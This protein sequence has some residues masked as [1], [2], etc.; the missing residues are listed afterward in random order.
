MNQKDI[1]EAIQRTYTNAQRLLKDSE[2]LEKKGSFASAVSLAILGYEEAMK[3]YQLTKYHPIFDGFFAKADLILLQKQL[4]SHFWKQTF[5]LELRISLEAIIDALS[6]K[7]RKEI[8]MPSRKE[9][10]E[11]TTFAITEKLEQMKN[12]GFYVDAFRS[13][14]WFPSAMNK[15]SVKFAQQLLRT[16][17][18]S[19]KEVVRILSQVDKIPEQER[20]SAKSELKEIAHSLRQVQK[21]E[22]NDLEDLDRRMEK[23]GVVGKIISSL[24]RA[25]ISDE[26]FELFEKERRKD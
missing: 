15:T 3:A 1:Q 24:A 11:G 6:E 26:R 13:P 23:Y 14:M 9:L 19:V 7:E 18:D 8:G 20:E 16:Q 25:Y 12:D 2:T 4:T 21:D 17:L 10:Q 22:V 5:A